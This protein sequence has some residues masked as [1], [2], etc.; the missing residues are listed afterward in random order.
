MPHEKLPAAVE[1][2]RRGGASRSA[3]KA[4][5]SRRNG[6]LG[7][8]PRGDAKRSQSKNPKNLDSGNPN[9]K[10]DATKSKTLSTPS[11]SS[12]SSVTPG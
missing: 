11:P 1:L 7:G 4:A 2:G 10:L 3:A 5:S 8:R 6:A 9:H 12:V